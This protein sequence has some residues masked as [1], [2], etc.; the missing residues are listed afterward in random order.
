MIEWVAQRLAGQPAHPAP[1]NQICVG[2]VKEDVNS[3]I[4][5]KKLPNPHFPLFWL[6]MITNLFFMVA[7][8]I[9]RQKISLDNSDDDTTIGTQRPKDL[10]SMLLNFTAII[11]LTVNILGYLLFWKK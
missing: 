11:L 9:G 4:S 2:G 6:L 8:K 5:P 10:E 7:I 3:K 1:T